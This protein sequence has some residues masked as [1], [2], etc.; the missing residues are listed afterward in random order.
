MVQRSGDQASQ[1]VTFV[2]NN[3]YHD[4]FFLKAQGELGPWAMRLPPARSGVMVAENTGS[5]EWGL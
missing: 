1:K 4:A 5:T 2:Q 3:F